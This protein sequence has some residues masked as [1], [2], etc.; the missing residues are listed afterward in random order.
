MKLEKLNT[1]LRNLC[2]K[3][4][5]PSWEC[6]VLYQGEVV[7]DAKSE[8]YDCKRR[9]YF[10]YS[11]T[12][13]V[14]CVAA[15]RLV[16][17]GMLS[18]DDKVSA[19]LPDFAEM[20]VQKGKV[21]TP[22]TK[23]LTVRHLIS[24]QGGYGYE[25]DMEDLVY[26]IRDNP[27]ASTQEIA[28]ALSKRPLKFEP[29]EGFGYSL[30]YDILGAVIEVASG[31][32]LG[33]YFKEKIFTPLEMD[34]TTFKLTSQMR[35]KLA[36]F[37]RYNHELGRPIE[38]VPASNEYIFTQNYESGGAGLISTF[39]DYFKFAVTL[40]NGGVTESG[41]C[42]LQKESIAQIH[43]RCMTDEMLYGYDRYQQ[44]GTGY[45]FGVRSQVDYSRCPQ[46]MSDENFELTGAA[47]S[48]AFW[49]LKNKL[50]FVYFQHAVGIK[51][52]SNVVHHKIRDLI[53]EDIENENY[54]GRK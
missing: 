23:A 51:E 22:T 20:Y 1:Y 53:Y 28:K 32:S 6:K 13:L 41:Y 45:S 42:L 26:T 19:Y 18:L 15:M 33:E 52:V 7:L 40:L 36:P 21:V 49:D 35:E 25:I 47:G 8:S 43:K 50:T 12:K 38:M 37:Y 24:M 46:F 2:G 34:N 5:I 44:W 27:N 48:C 4:G 9:H 54:F 30:C 10:I 11:M 31:K 16:E 14:T 39:D 29:G 17:D 3:Y